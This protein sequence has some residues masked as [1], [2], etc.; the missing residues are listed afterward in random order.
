M[1]P[2]NSRRADKAT[3]SFTNLKQADWLTV[4]NKVGKTKGW[5]DEETRE[6]GVASCRP[7]AARYSSIYK[8]N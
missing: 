3:E 1:T 4:P 8:T 7:R 2:K 6:L 5:E